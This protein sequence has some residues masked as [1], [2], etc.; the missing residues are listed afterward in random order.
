[1]AHAELS[2]VLDDIKTLEPGELHQVQQVVKEQ[3]GR[4][5]SDESDERALKAM[6]KA[7]LIIEIKRPS[8]SKKPERRLISMQGKPIS[9]TIIE[10][11]R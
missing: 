9:E 4:F 11:R 10:E 8:R 6:L 1:M 2:R 7:G 5:N 3:L